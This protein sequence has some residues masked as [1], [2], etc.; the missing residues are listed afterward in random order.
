MEDEILVAIDG[1]AHSAKIVDVASE[2]AKGLSQ[3]I[4]LVYVLK[5][6]LEE[7]E[8]LAAYEKAED[9]RDA[10]AD[11]LEEY[12][13]QITEEFGHRIEKLGVQFR[14]ITPSGNPASEI[15]EIA[16]LEK[17]KMIVVGMK[18]HHGIVHIRSLGSVARRVIENS[19]SPVVVIPSNK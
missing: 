18:G 13:R 4:L 8:G 12:G 17:V 2:L 5:T 15:I 19:Q 16:R 9:Y 10:Y 1:S 11:Y 14:S 7:P 6:P 3:K